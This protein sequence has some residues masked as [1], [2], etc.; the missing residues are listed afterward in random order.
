MAINAPALSSWLLLLSV[1]QTVGEKNLYIYIGRIVLLW[2]TSL[3]LSLR[4]SEA[5]VPMLFN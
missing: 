1:K 4:V 2:L 5:H 3:S